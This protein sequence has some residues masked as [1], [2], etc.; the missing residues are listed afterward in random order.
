MQE[1]PCPDLFYSPGDVA[2]QFTAALPT[3]PGDTFIFRCNVTGDRSGVTL[4]IVGSSSECPLLHSTPDSHPCG[5]GS[6]FTARSVVG[7]GID[8]TSFTSTLSGTATPTLNGTLVECFGPAFS[9][10]SDNMVG[11]STLQILG[12]LT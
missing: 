1:E 11:N 6:P 7:F 10:G 4:W 9:R 3:C 8:A 2:G 5:T 12:Q